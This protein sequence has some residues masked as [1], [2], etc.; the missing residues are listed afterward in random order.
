MS[1]IKD[2][3]KDFIDKEIERRIS[4]NLA[5]RNTSISFEYEISNDN[6][7]PLGIKDKNERL[8]FYEE[9]K[10]KLKTVNS[11]TWKD[12]GLIHKKIGYETIPYKQFSEN[13]KRSLKM[14]NIIS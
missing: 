13:I 6:Y 9:L 11:T 12:F 8:L 5:Y 4:P 3:Q 1:R 10:K 2:N 14:T 7:S